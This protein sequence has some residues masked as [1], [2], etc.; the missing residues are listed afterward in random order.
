MIIDEEPYV[1][2][3]LGSESWLI[4]DDLDEIHLFNK[5]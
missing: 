5:I 1:A 3:A 2:L 4:K